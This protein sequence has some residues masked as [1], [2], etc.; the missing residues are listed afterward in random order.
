[1]NEEN[2][3]ALGK[4]LSNSPPTIFNME[5]FGRCAIGWAAKDILIKDE[6]EGWLKYSRRF[7]GLSPQGPEWSWLFRGKWESV[8]NSPQGVATRIGILVSSGLPADWKE[9]MLGLKP[10][11]YEKT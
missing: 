7:T 6:G 5:K 11:C 4:Y 1:M 8:D 9:Q 10:L 2:L 3:L